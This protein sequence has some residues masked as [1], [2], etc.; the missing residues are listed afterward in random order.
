MK[1]GIVTFPGSNWKPNT[2]RKYG[3]FLVGANGQTLVRY[4]K[5]VG[6]E[7]SSKGISSPGI[8]E[9]TRDIVQCGPAREITLK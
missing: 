7:I 5:T 2:R 3:V 9:L 1:F 8:T 6:N 4:Y